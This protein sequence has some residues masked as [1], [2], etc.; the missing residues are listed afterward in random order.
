LN[1][2]SK[3]SD[4]FSL[5]LDHAEATYLSDE[6][7]IA[8]RERIQ[9]A[10]SPDGLANL[11]KRIEEYIAGQRELTA[12]EFYL[13]FEQ[14]SV[15][16]LLHTFLRRGE[17][18]R[19]A[20]GLQQTYG[21]HIRLMMLGF[22]MFDRSD[23]GWLMK[24]RWRNPIDVEQA[25]LEDSVKR[26]HDLKLSRSERIAIWIAS[27]LHDYGKIF[28]RG[29]GLDA[30]DAA[31]LCDTLV[32]A[33]SPDGMVE[34]IHYGIRNHDLI[35]H[36]VTGD[37]PA[38]FIK[39]PIEGLPEDKRARALPMLALIQ[40]I[41]AASLGEGRLARAKLDIYNACLS[42]DIVDD[43]SA[44]ARFGRLLFGRQ[45]VPD[46]SAKARAG[47]V[48]AGLD[49]P[50]RT[51]LMKLLDRTVVL[52]WNPVRENILAEEADDSKALSRLVRTLV[53]V[54]RLW[55][56]RPAPPT[57]IVLARPQELA[58]CTRAGGDN[59]ARL[60]NEDAATELLNGTSALILR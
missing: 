22:D 58:K 39:E 21:D 40:Q 10:Y 37:T 50:D 60:K 5:T 45:A 47:A 1:Q 33:L 36:T 19:H 53:L 29:Y 27:A 51:I 38:C 4:M 2:I 57:H 20:N 35:E 18:N 7:F 8:R 12:L 55:S 52:G 43:G 15:L 6:H 46:A 48:L 44:E 56:Q 23:I 59:G 14:A 25:E 24:R 31:P 16:V 54:G 26:Y 3:I 9:N 41:G 30:E 28:R 42:G 11:K 13:A 17:R 32:E 49:D 34:L